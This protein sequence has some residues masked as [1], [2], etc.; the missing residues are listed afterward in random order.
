MPDLGVDC[1]KPDDD[2]LVADQPALLVEVLSPTTSGFDVTVKL[3]EY[4]ALTPLDY[5]L[6]VDTE[7]P[8][9]HLYFRGDDR[10]WQ[11]EV[12]KGIDASI[13]LPKLKV[14]LQLADILRRSPV[15]SP[16]DR[17]SRGGK[18]AAEL[19]RQHTAIIPRRRRITSAA[20]SPA[21]TRRPSSASVASAIRHCSTHDTER[22]FPPG[23]DRR[24]GSTDRARRDRRFAGGS[25]PCSGPASCRG[26]RRS[27]NSGCWP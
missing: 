1:G 13:A 23:S 5:I 3:A 17:W 11:N 19:N 22:A 14:K 18:R 2:A 27:R 12:I 15:P 4:Q 24:T 26:R 21:S 8:N 6:F 20:P 9:A 10:R 16:T 7:R 25:G